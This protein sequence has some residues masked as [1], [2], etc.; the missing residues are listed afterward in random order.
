MNLLIVCTRFWNSIY[1][2]INSFYLN[3]RHY[4]F[5]SHLM[6]LKCTVSLT[7]EQTCRCTLMCAFLIRKKSVRGSAFLSLNTFEIVYTLVPRPRILSLCSIKNSNTESDRVA[8]VRENYQN[9]STA[10]FLMNQNVF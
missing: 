3:L 1:L 8:Q 5:G 6:R 10:F 4:C 7:A 2:E 9:K